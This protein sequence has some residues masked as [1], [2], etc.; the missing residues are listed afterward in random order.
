MTKKNTF[1][2]VLVSTAVAASVLAPAVPAHASNERLRTSIPPHVVVDGSFDPD[3]EVVMVGDGPTTQSGNC[4]D[5]AFTV[6]PVMGQ[7]VNGCNMIGWNAAARAPYKWYKHMGTTNP[8]I[9]GKGFNSK[10][11]PTWTAIG[12]G[13]GQTKTVPWGNVAGT[14]K[15]KGLTAVGW[16]GVQWQ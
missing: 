4:K 14:K 7:S 16:A 1:S 2:A 6:L 8:C 15:M 9:W 3:S 12:C 11:A 5:R 13:S 10:H